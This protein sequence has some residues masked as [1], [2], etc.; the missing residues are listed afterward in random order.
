MIISSANKEQYRCII[1]NV[2]KKVCLPI[3]SDATANDCFVYSPN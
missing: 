1:P 2:D 3:F